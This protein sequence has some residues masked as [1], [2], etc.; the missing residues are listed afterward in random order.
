MQLEKLDELYN[1]CQALPNYQHR[2]LSEE[3]LLKRAALSFARLPQT[4]KELVFKTWAEKLGKA[5]PEPEDTKK[6]LLYRFAAQT[7]L[8]FLCHLLEKYNQTTVFSHEEICNSFFVRKDPTFITFE[9]FANQYTD[10]KERLLLVPRGGFK[11]SIDMAD[12]VQWIICFPEVTILVLTGVLS[13]AN[14]FVG[15]IKGHFTLEEGG[16]TDLF[17]GKK[18]LRP[19]RMNDGT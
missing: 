13:L 8:Y 16:T 12:C 3:E 1:Y 14:D 10:L 4:Q 19:R 15:E 2:D 7:N 6:L 9:Q 17:G 5:K 18:Q 11:S